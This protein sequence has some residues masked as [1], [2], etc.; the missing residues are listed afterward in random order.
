MRGVSDD[1]SPTFWPNGFMGDARGNTASGSRKLSPQL[2]LAVGGRSARISS[3]GPS[4]SSEER[5][6]ASARSRGMSPSVGVTSSLALGCLGEDGAFI[7]TGVFINNEF[8]ATDSQIAVED[9]G[10]GKEICSIHLG[11]EKH[12]DLAVDSAR[13]CFSSVWKKKNGR[14]RSDLLLRMSEL[15]KE[16][17]DQ[18]ADLEALECGKPKASNAIF[19]VLHSGDVF[20]YYSSLA[21]SAED[22]K[23]IETDRS[24]FT[25][26]ITEPYGVC[27]A[28]MAWNFPM[29]T[30]AWK[31][32]PCLA[33]GNA[34]VVKTSENTPLS[35]LFMCELFVKAGAPPGLVNVVCGLGAKVGSH[36]AA[37]KGIDKITFTGS[38]GVGKIIQKLAAENLK[39]CT[40]ECGGKSPLIVYDDA[41]L[42]QA[43]K[44]AAFGIF[45]NKGEIC[46]ASS[47][48]YVQDSIYDEFL[49][50]LKSHVQQNFVQGS[51]FTEGVNVGP[52]VSKAQQ[53]KILEYVKAGV[54]EGA[55]LVLGGV[56]T[57]K[58]SEGYYIDPTILADCNQKMRVVQ[59]EIF[60]PVVTVAKFSTDDEAIA[61]SNDSD[62]GLAAYLFT[63]NLNRSQK[64]IREVESGQVFVNYTFAADYRMPFGGY[65]M[66]GIGRE[67]GEAG[68]AAF[69]QTKAVHIN[70]T[71]ERGRGVHVPPRQ[72]NI[73]HYTVQHIFKRNMSHSAESPAKL[74]ATGEPDAQS[75]A[76][77]LRP[78]ISSLLRVK[79]RPMQ[80]LLI[81]EYSP[82]PKAPRREKECPQFLDSS[83]TQLLE[84]RK[85]TDLY[86]ALAS[87]SLTP[88]EF[89]QLIIRASN[90]T[91]AYKLCQQHRD[92]FDYSGLS[93]PFLE[94][95]L[96]VLYMNF[97]Y[98]EFDR[99]FTVY[100]SRVDEPASDCLR[101][102][103]RIYLKTEN[104]SVATQI[105]NQSVMSSQ[106]LSPDVLD[107]YLRDLQAHTFNSSLC[108]MAYRLWVS[109]GFAVHFRT[110][111]LLYKFV[112]S[113]GTQEQE[114]WVI[115]QLEK[116]GCYHAWFID[117]LEEIATPAEARRF[118]AK[119]YGEW[120]GR[121]EPGEKESF[122]SECVHMLMR[123]GEI[124]WVR[125]ILNHTD[126]QD[127]FEVLLKRVLWAL[128][129]DCRPEVYARLLVKLSEEIRLRFREEYFYDLWKCYGKTYPALRKEITARFQSHMH[130]DPT[131][132]TGRYAS[133]IQNDRVSLRAKVVG[134]Q[135][136]PVLPTMGLIESRL[137]SGIRP[138]PG[139]LM[140]AIN[141]TRSL[142]EL[143]KLT[144]FVVSNPKILD[145]ESVPFKLLLFRK[146]KTL[147][148]HFRRGIFRFLGQLVEDSGDQLTA[149]DLSSMLLESAKFHNH[150]FG[151]VLLSR[152]AELQP[153]DSTEQ[154][155]VIYAVIRFFFDQGR[156]DQVILLLEV[157]K[158]DPQ[159]C[160]TDYFVRNVKSAGTF[161]AANVQH[162]EIKDKFETYL[163]HTV[164][165]LYEQIQK[166]RERVLRELDTHLEL[167]DRWRLQLLDGFLDAIVR[168]HPDQKESI[169]RT[170]QERSAL[171]EADTNN[172]N[173]YFR[174]L[175]E[176]YS[177][178]VLDTSDGIPRCSVCHWEAH[179]SRCMN[180]GRRLLGANDDDDDDSDSDDDTR[181]DYNFSDETAQH[182]HDHH[183]EADFSYLSS[184]EPLSYA[185]S[186]DGGEEVDRERLATFVTGF[187]MPYLIDRLFFSRSA[188]E[189]SMDSSDMDYVGSSEAGSRHEQI[190]EDRSEEGSDE[191]F[192]R[193]R[194]RRGTRLLSSDSDNDE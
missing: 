6:S 90:Y 26:T 171:Y 139:L 20:R 94:K 14:E 54:E 60:G 138:R 164:E 29:S 42:D 193:W 144:M 176:N 188:D 25:Y 40:L 105:F 156:P 172:G 112:M 73:D 162:P 101:L 39:V 58:Y 128:Q 96:L 184:D 179:G 130:A 32:A 11:D 133:V 151:N 95:L 64:Y 83:L 46:T 19:D 111:V 62:Y 67:L 147:N 92:I 48:I 168:D 15:I 53:D 38:T 24:K 51:Q 22:G 87:L 113:Q 160:P 2:Q 178:A 114:E 16:H 182:D 140:T 146:R 61:L 85:Y 12:V 155:R 191:G 34:I 127:E 181:G 47:R 194:A 154:L 187:T 77:K 150:E 7:S 98:T 167:L 165:C 70:L 125:D 89:E 170:V 185:E 30:F 57:A 82:K 72:H 141:A 121:L 122:L 183:D 131:M 119:E 76:A 100:L 152:I 120:L 88:L 107:S 4:E 50:K 137:R 18:L 75:A 159:F 118:M 134:D 91:F 21:I 106:S 27:A 63:S 163:Q 93:T 99:I 124:S 148:P 35:A 126:T 186:P 41:D 102:A 31:V 174:K 136:A 80:D 143:D 129:N 157:I 117:E 45:F 86:K 189:E 108:F 115:G 103:L 149:T 116:D 56:K 43:V 190:E 9:P 8:L 74:T 1:V 49:E 3:V 33:A 158:A 109:K 135:A 123:V 23:T 79:K 142:D 28:I 173:G 192:Q 78:D 153:H 145:P 97:D 110:R 17:S 13:A 84:A 55:R 81:G 166:Q 59:E 37:H 65:K 132:L 71:I 177:E 10:T 52:Q 69:S 104:V 169:T 161:Y 68:L 5:S 175:F 36:I 44:W 180:C 66:S